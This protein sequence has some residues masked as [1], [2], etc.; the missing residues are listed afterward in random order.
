MGLRVQDVFTVVCVLSYPKEKKK[1][2][3]H[4]KGAD[5]HRTMLE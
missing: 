1:V 2:A 5:S 3:G 4:T